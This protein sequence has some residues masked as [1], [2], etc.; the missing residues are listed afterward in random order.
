MKTLVTPCETT[1]YTVS[2]WLVMAEIFCKQSR[3][4]GLDR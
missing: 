2:M 3:S 4:L 1:H